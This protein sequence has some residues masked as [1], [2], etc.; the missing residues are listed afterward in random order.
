MRFSLQV[1][2]TCSVPGGYSL[3][4]M[5]SVVRDNQ[6]LSWR[7]SRFTRVDRDAFAE[8]MASIGWKCVWAPQF[9]SSERNFMLMLL[10][11]Q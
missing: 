7:F 1:E 9:G 6:L 2:Q 11:K 5:A 8:V 10:R 4:A 3:E